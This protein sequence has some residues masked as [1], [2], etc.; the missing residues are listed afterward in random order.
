MYIHI[1]IYLLLQLGYRNAERRQV[2]P[3]PPSNGDHGPTTLPKYTYSTASMSELVVVKGKTVTQS[4]LVQYHLD[5][6][7][8]AY[9]RGQWL[10]PNWSSKDFCYLPGRSSIYRNRCQ[11]IISAKFEFTCSKLAVAC[12]KELHGV[13]QILD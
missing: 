5:E 4:G 2:P 7:S 6:A 3:S 1:Y 12:L 11:N 13:C 8:Q 9:K 10:F